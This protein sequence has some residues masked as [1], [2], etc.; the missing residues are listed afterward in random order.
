[1]IGTSYLDRYNQLVK[2][3]LGIKGEGFE[4][5]APEL[6][7]DITLEQTP[8]LA[9]EWYYLMGVSR[10]SSGRQITAV[11]AAGLFSAVEMLNPAGS[12]VLVTL[13]GLWLIANDLA[14]PSSYTMGIDRTALGGGVGNSLPALDTRESVSKVSASQFR[15]TATAATQPITDG[16]AIDIQTVGA[17]SEENAL[18][19]LSPGIVLAPGH[20]LSVGPRAAV[21]ATSVIFQFRERQLGPSELKA[22]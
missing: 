12:G 13:E 7:A 19:S 22:A 3:L 15:I 6:L 1:V 2:L 5:L 17:I 11:P 4:G 20:R 18:F 14:A 8:A 9:Y 16:T 21:Q 10:Y